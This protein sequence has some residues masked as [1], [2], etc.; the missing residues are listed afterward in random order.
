MGELVFS[1]GLRLIGN[2]ILIYRGIRVAALFFK[3]ENDLDD[4]LIVEG[5]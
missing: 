5:L 4:H 2:L 3:L 1:I